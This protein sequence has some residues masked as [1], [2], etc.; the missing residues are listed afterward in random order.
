[1]RIPCV[2]TFSLPMLGI[3]ICEI[4]A[5][6]EETSYLDTCVCSS[7]SKTLIIWLIAASVEFMCR[8]PKT[9]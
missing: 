9:K 2:G 3:S 4:T 8:V 6:S 7:P 1:M 5:T